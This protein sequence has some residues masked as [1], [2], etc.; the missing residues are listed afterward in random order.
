MFALPQVRAY[1]AGEVEWKRKLDE[2]H[3]TM[4][5]KDVEQRELKEEL[6]TEKTTLTKTTVMLRAQLNAAEDASYG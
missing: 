4:R 6:M 5:R 1:Q 2:A 3:E